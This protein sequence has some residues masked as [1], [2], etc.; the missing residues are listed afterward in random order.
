MKRRDAVLALPA[1]AYLV[2]IGGARAGA[3]LQRI[4]YFGVLPPESPSVVATLARFREDLGR[5]GLT[6]GRDYT[7]DY[8][9]EERVDRIPEKM[10]ALLEREVSLVVAI[11]TPVALAAA[12]ATRKIPI[13]FGTVS[14][15]IGSGLVARI[16]RP[17]GNITGV[18]NLLP[19]LSGK[20]LELSREIVPGAV[21]IAVM[22][23]PENPAKALELRELRVAAGRASVALAELPVRSAAEI[24]KAIAGVGKDV[25]VIVTLAETLTNANRQRIATLARMRHL[26][27][28]FNLAAHVEAGG[29]VSY[30]PDYGALNRRLGD[31]AGR[32]LKGA[33]PGTLPVEQPTTFELVVNKGTAK[34]LG[35]SIPQTVLL[36]ATKVIE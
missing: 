28:V 6:D 5:H 22:W 14:D 30:S 19:E 15:P 13:V 31:L 8:V 1:L 17:G 21:R 18:T 36:R 3:S 24:E 29:L 12:K 2:S 10:R 23:N 11:T 27:T 34:S 32:I 9:W 35:I 33:D 16:D 4:V 25:S 26:P 20:L 7:L